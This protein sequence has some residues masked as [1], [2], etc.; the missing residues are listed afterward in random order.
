MENYG[1]EINYCSYCISRDFYFDMVEAV[2]YYKE[3]VSLWIS[4]IK[5]SKDFVLAYDLGRFIRRRIF[6]D[7]TGYDL[8]MAVPLSKERLRKR[9]FNQSFL[10][11]WGLLGKRPKDKVLIRTKDTKPQTELTQK[12]RWENVKEAFALH[13]EQVKDQRVLIVDDVMTTGATLNEISKVLKKGGAK[14][15]DILVVARSQLE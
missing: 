6:L 14:R 3:P 7:L 10:I 12:E 8:I 4:K 15:V 11:G 2:F 1:K 5:F 9:G 13:T